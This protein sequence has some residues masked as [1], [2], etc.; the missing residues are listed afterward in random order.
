V[1]ELFENTFSRARLYNLQ[2]DVFE[3]LMEASLAVLIDVMRESERLVFFIDEGGEILKQA[4][5]PIF[6]SF[7]YG[8]ALLAYE[9]MIP[10]ADVTEQLEEKYDEQKNRR[11]AYEREHSCIVEIEELEEDD[12]EFPVLPELRER[13]VLPEQVLE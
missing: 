9:R 6:A 4:E 1:E 7:W 11:K 8:L 13:G 5:N 10:Q 12:F 3:E 2:E